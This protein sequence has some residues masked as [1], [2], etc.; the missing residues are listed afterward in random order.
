[1]RDVA[2]TLVK[3]SGDDVVRGLPHDADAA[4]GRLDMNFTEHPSHYLRAQYDALRGFY[5][6]AAEQHLATAMWWD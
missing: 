6:L 1:V 3:W 4:T 5:Q 2:S